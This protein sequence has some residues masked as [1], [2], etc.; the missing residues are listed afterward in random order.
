MKHPL[1]PVIIDPKGVQRFQKNAIVD[2]LLKFGRNNGTGLN[3]LAIMDFSRED[4]IQFYQLIGH[5][6][7]GFTELSCVD[8]D[9]CRAIDIMIEQGKDEKSARIEA[10][11]TELQELRKA[12]VE[13]MARLF[14]IHPDDLKNNLK[15]D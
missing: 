8:D 7:S 6:V 11:E 1:Q 10:L 4:W 2:F 9:T 5:S 14:G 15:E 12:L 13:P 3:E